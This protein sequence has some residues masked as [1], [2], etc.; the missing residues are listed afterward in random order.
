MAVQL[1]ADGNSSDAEAL[2]RF[3]LSTDPDA[4][5]AHVCLARIRAARGETDAAVAGLVDAVRV[6]AAAGPGDPTPLYEMLAAALELAPE[7]IDLHI[8]LAE[9]QAAHGDVPGAQARL[10]QLSAIYVDAGRHDDARDVLAVAR[11]WDPQGSVAGVIVDSMQ[12]EESVE[13]LLEE[14]EDTPLPQPA[15]V[16]QRRATATVCTPTLLRDAEGDVLPDQEVVPAPAMR[17]RSPRASTI[18]TPTLLRDA[19]GQLLPNQRGVPK[20]APERGRGRRQR[21]P[22]P[23]THAAKRPSTGRSPTVPTSRTSIRTLRARVRVR[24][25]SEI[26]RDAPLATRLRRLGGLQSK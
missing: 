24:H 12:I 2:V 3:A 17:R 14:V 7:R 22:A 10:V 25:E 9:L 23:P 4:S 5:H 18:C 16:P 1:A 13:I 11:G 26:D 19:H 8:D 20:P 15:P 21:V 6:R